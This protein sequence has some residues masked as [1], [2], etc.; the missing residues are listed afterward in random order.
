MLCVGSYTHRATSV[1]KLADVA[2]CDLEGVDVVGVDGED[3][4]RAALQSMELTRV[5]AARVHR[6]TVLSRSPAVL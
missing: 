6:G 5:C 4:A 3:S 2:S 1:S